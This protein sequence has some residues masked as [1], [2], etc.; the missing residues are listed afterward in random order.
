M[1]PSQSRMSSNV[2]SESNYGGMPSRVSLR[3]QQSSTKLRS[4]YENETAGDLV[5]RTSSAASGRSYSSQGSGS[6]MRSAS[7][8]SPYA[9][10]KPQQPPPLPNGYPSQAQPVDGRG[11]KRDSNSSNS[12]DRS[13][14]FSAPQSTSPVT[15]FGSSD[16][17][18]AH[19]TLRHAMSNV[20]LSNGT[21]PLPASGP[22]TVK[23]KVH[24][25]EDLFVII[26]NRRT[27]FQ[28]LVDKVGKKIR[29]CG[30]RK[31]GGALRI[32]Y[33]DEDGDMVS[34]GSDEDVQMAFDTSRV[35][36]GGQVTLFVA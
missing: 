1:R 36:S 6:R 3:T 15:P 12:T 28:E 17:S 16:S 13:S 11:V 20:T 5:A 25:N 10:P 19:G 23:V 9:A 7:I 21:K 18:L 30:G 26:V 4:T 8:S 29:L 31:E 22:L 2:V 35:A 33:R 32:R 34:L 27:D 14:D 24:Y